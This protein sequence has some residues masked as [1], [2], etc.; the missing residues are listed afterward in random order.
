[1]TLRHFSTLLLLS[2]LIAT[3]AYG[4][5][6]S[7]EK[8][9]LPVVL[10]APVR[11]AYGSVFNTQLTILNSSRTTVSV[12]GFGPSQ[13]AIDLC[14]SNSLDPNETR[15]FTPFM[16]A[17]TVG[18]FLYVDRNFS[19]AVRVQ[20]RA[21]DSSHATDTFGTE[22]PI[23]RESEALQGPTELLSIPTDRNFRNLVRIYG[24]DSG[25][26]DPV[27]VRI[28]YRGAAGEQDVLYEERLLNLQPGPS[29]DYPS[30]AQFDITALTPFAVK[31]VRVEVVP[32]NPTLRYYTFA[33]VTNNNTQHITLV[34]PQ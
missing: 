26:S 23:V 30:Y 24:F 27:L 15:T 11:G 21:F 6:A 29:E 14:N 20:L 19:N 5:I 16:Q 9:L 34:T 3:A 31:E 1:M 13:C 7:Q 10:S 33:S 17:G 28:Y 12:R 25:S 22:I 2:L 32:V 4:Q 18:R 8:L